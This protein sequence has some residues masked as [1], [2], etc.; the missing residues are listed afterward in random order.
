MYG[1]F[2]HHH[3]TC[4]RWHRMQARNITCALQQTHI[5]LRLCGFAPACVYACCRFGVPIVNTYN[6]T[7]K[8]HAGHITD[9]PVS[10]REVDCI[11]YCSPGVPEVCLPAI[12]THAL[13]CWL[14]HITTVIWYAASLDDPVFPSTSL[15]PICLRTACMLPEMH[16]LQQ[17]DEQLGHWAMTSMTCDSG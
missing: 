2:S 3:T 12:D 4:R 16:L 5:L 7:V 15:G 8:L 10:G 13:T 9:R 6:E 11:H 14:T 17:L 1:A